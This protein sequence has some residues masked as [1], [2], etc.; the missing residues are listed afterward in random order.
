MQGELDTVVSNPG[1]LRW[2]K[3]TR[4]VKPEDKSKIMFAKACHELH[5][6]PMNAEVLKHALKFIAKMMAKPGAT[7]WE[8]AKD[9]RQGLLGKIIRSPQ[10]KLARMLIFLYLV[11]GL[12]FVLIKKRRRLFL[13][14]PGAILSNLAIY[15]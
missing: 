2:F 1:A 15:K 8:K 14:W 10:V 13:Q 7:T 5:K 3:N 9:V 11:I 4:N 12:L 6:E